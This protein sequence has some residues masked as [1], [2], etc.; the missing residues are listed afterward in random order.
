MQIS[1]SLS[2]E[3]GRNAVRMCSIN[4]PTTLEIA[5]EIRAEL[6]RR[7]GSVADIVRF[8]DADVR[9]EYAAQPGVWHVRAVTLPVGLARHWDDAIHAVRM[10]HPRAH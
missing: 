3:C 5:C 7:A 9:I 10:R 4:D 8:E 2:V 6:K 1:R